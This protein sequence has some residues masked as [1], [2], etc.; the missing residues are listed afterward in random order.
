VSDLQSHLNLKE[1]EEAIADFS[2]D[3]DEE[4]L[5][6]VEWVLVGKVLSPN[7]CPC[8]YRA[9]GNEAG[10]GQP[11]W[12]EVLSN[13]REGKQPVCGRVWMQT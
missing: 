11:C 4:V 10:M 5:P 3:E 7:T 2:D 12:P 1:H 13:W 9:L 8:E 6:R